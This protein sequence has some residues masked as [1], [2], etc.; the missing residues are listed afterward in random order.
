MIS[1]RS[2]LG[3]ASVDN[4]LLLPETQGAPG[5]LPAGFNHTIPEVVER[6]IVRAAP[7]IIVRRRLAF[8]RIVAVDKYYS[9]DVLRRL[10]LDDDGVVQRVVIEV[11]RVHEAREER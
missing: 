3:L 2:H 8:L 5:I 4:G 1:A 10:V 7:D 6:R 9:D 11:W